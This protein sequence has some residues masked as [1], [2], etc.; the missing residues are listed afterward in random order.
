MQR[1][2]ERYAEDNELG[3]QKVSATVECVCAN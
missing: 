1:F 3:F 2:M